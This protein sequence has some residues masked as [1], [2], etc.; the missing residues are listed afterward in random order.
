[1][2]IKRVKPGDIIHVKRT[3]KKEDYQ[4]FFDNQWKVE[5]VYENHVLTTSL[6]TPQIRRCFDYGDLVL[7]GLELQ[8]VERTLYEGRHL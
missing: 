8:Y 1:M 7:L 4:M 6:K 2:K 5:K 3:P